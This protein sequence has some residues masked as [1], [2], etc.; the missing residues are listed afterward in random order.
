[1]S[2]TR[3]DNGPSVFLTDEECEAN[4]SALIDGELDGTLL[5]PTIDHLVRSERC[6]RFYRDARLLRELL[7]GERA[8]RLVQEKPAD[9]WKKIEWR[10]G[11]HR[12]QVFRLFSKRS[13]FWAAAAAVLL[14]LGLW[15]G[16]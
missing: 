15:T 14:V 11:L 6:R 16:G 5:L 10:S 2:G 1:M 12:P 4:L 3:I 13:P 9:T 8:K 7:S